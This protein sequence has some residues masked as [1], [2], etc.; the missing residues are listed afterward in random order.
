M[1]WGIPTLSI[2]S[3]LDVE[4]E[5]S[6]R[7][8]ADYPRGYM[9][10]AQAPI[11]Q[12][13]LDGF[14]KFQQENNRSPGSFDI[15]LMTPWVFGKKYWWR[16]QETGSCVWSNTFRRVVDRAA[17][18]I[19]LRGDAGEY[20][21][22]TEFSPSSIAPSLASYGF[23]RERAK[24]KGLSANSDGLYRAPMPD[25]MLKDG[26]VSC[27]TPKLVEL[28]KSLGLTKEDALPEPFGNPQLY[29]RFGN[30]E[31]NRLLL[32]YAD[33][34]LLEAPPI[35][36][37]EQLLQNFREFKPGLQCS[38]IAIKKIGTHK[39]GFSIHARDTS[40]S[41]GHNMGYGGLRVG[42]D[43]KEYVIITNDSWIFPNEKEPWKYVYNVPVEEVADWFKRD[44]LDSGT[45][46][47]IDLPK[48]MPPM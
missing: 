43:G 2:R 38:G 1:G 28:F 41:W 11:P 30:W 35:T 46:G 29:R 37:I 10:R 22:T 39:D 40:T 31:F 9:A 33:H 12:A 19:A 47:E 6:E 7:L 23:A 20:F 44:L 3:N 42:S 5:A 48:P 13:L 16:P 34:R 24:M 14:N 45:I 27:S 25:S 17:F 26:F 21:G 36:S 15:T 8:A 32:P 18:Q 4:K